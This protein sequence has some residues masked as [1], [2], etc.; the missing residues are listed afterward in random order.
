MVP[1]RPTVGEHAWVFTPLSFA[2]FNISLR[3]GIP[4]VDRSC[5]KCSLVSSSSKKEVKEFA[6]AFV[7]SFVPPKGKQMYVSIPFIADNSSQDQRRAKPIGC[8][9][10]GD[11]HELV[12]LDGQFDRS[13]MK[14]S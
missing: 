9:P 14:P 10:A 5:L 13:E 6:D 12:P 4:A 2:C 11:H 3:D 8:A 1:N 7:R